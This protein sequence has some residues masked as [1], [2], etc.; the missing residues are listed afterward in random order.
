M[1]SSPLLPRVKF[2]L[3]TGETDRATDDGLATDVAGTDATLTEEAEDEADWEEEEEAR[4]ETPPPPPPHATAD[5]GA[6]TGLDA[7][8]S[9][10]PVPL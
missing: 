5:P 9:G 1:T 3:N 10:L 6:F 7:A 2:L 8:D 4:I